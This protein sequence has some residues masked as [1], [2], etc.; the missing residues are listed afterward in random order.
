M[1]VFLKTQRLMLRNLCSSDE[2][3]VF[4]W[5][6]DPICAKYQRWEDTT[7]SEIEGYIS[8]HREDIFPSLKEEQHYAIADYS[9]NAVGELAYFYT[10][11]D[12]CITLGITVSL[13]FHR[14]GYAFEMLQTIVD[15]IRNTYPELE[16]VGLIDKDNTASI[17]LFEKL[18]FIRECYAESI[19]SYVYTLGVG[20]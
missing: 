14:Q 19:D 5:R 4:H 6:N 11:S 17:R 16:I 20:I 9:G 7:R 10:A 12:C 18:G 3:A 13:P 15:K 8:R 1:S 2:E